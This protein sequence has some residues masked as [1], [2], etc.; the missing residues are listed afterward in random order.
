M[1]YHRFLPT[2]LLVLTATVILHAQSDNVWRKSPKA[3][4]TGRRWDVPVGYA[5]DL[6]GF[7]VLGG[8]MSF[9]DAK[10]SRSYDVLA[11]DEKKGQW[12]NHFAIA[13][14][15]FELFTGNG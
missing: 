11:L 4:I 2:V 9:A 14:A 10:K 15:P 6:Q 1:S 12:E 8:R 13:G 3:E 7:L 5:P